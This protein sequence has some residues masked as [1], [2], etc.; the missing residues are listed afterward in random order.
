MS[1]GV[2]DPETAEGTVPVAAVPDVE[3]ATPVAPESIGFE[4]STGAPAPVG[5]PTGLTP[6]AG[7]ME[8]LEAGGAGRGFFQIRDI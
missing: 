6:P 2:V 5:D 4:A 8:S 3:G 1:P 7:A